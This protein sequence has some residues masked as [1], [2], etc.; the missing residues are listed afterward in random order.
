[1]KE[2]IVIFS[3]TWKFAATFPVAIYVFQMSSYETLLYTNLGGLLGLIFFSF[4]SRG[5]LSLFDHYWPENWRCKTKKRKTFGKRNRRLIILKKKYGLPGIVILTPVILS[6][7]VGAFLN[8]KYYGKKKSSY[9]YLFLGQVLW[10]LIY[11]LGWIKLKI[12]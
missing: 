9:L 12:I 6:I 11:T 4:L 1:M 7:P 2:L 8:V 10:S 3:A 5:L